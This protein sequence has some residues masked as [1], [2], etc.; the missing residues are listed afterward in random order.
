MHV[1]NSKLTL[2][3]LPYNGFRQLTVLNDKQK[4][5]QLSMKKNS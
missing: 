3:N 2:F 1:N 5:T 4:A